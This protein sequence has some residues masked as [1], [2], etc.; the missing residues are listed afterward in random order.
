MQGN[1]TSAA[2]HAESGVA[3]ETAG[4]LRSTFRPVYGPTVT[5]LLRLSQTLRDGVDAAL[6][7]VPAATLVASVNDASPAV[8]RS[9]G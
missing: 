1:T 9:D 3:H 4:A 7:S 8:I 6:V 2:C 5:Q